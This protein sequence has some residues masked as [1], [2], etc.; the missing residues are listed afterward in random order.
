MFIKHLSMEE[1]NE[2][3]RDWEGATNRHVSAI[4]ITRSIDLPQSAAAFSWQK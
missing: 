3:R 2:R 1:W 4:L